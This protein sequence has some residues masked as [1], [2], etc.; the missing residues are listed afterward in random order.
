MKNFVDLFPMKVKFLIPLM[1]FALVFTAC[2]DDDDMGPSPDPDPDPDPKEELVEFN[3]DALELAVANALGKTNGPVS[4]EEIL[5]LT[6]LNISGQQIEDL[7]GLEEAVNLEKFEAQSTSISS[8]V[9]ISQLSKMK[10]LDIRNTAIPNGNL[11]F[12]EGITGLEF[13]DFR[14]TGISDISNLALLTSLKEIYL[15]D[16]NIEDLSPLAGLTQ[17]I[18]LNIHTNPITDL[19]PIAGLTNLETLIMRNVQTGNEGLEVIKNFSKLW[20]LNARNT[21]ITDLTIL[22][23]MMA[24]GALQD[25]PAELI[26]ADVDIRENDFGDVTAENDPY[27]PIRPYWGNIDSRAPEILPEPVGGGSV[28]PDGAFEGAVR[29]ALG[30]GSEDEITDEMLLGLEEL[31]AR[32]LPIESIEGIDRMLNLTFLRLD[33]TDVTDLSPM[34]ALTKL[35]YFNIN[36]TTGITDI[37]A[38]AN[39]T[40]LGTLIARNVPF[41][42]E[43]MATIA[44]FTKLH[45]LNM[46][47]TGVTD[48]SVLADLMAQGALQNENAPSNTAILDIREID[49]NDFCV[50][51]PYIGNIGDLSGGDFTDCE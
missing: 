48:L 40:E 1:A 10:W 3:D 15:R 9:P 49:A 30:I 16:N 28:F 6:E 19:S 21:G 37:S 23:E 14:G 25:N 8:F 41:G 4:K 20:R 51:Y 33:G 50:I 5:E 18:Y 43:G 7:T 42:N 45:R 47:N 35:D 29:S 22:G 39:N 34:V 12:L 2:G 46:R 17:L 31:D 44:N 24:A 27:A 36:T 26:F 38:L 13:V 11:S 32:G